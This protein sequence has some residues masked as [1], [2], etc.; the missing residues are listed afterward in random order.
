MNASMIWT[1]EITSDGHAIGTRIVAQGW[2]ILSKLAAVKAAIPTTWQAE[3][4]P[5][6]NSESSPSLSDSPVA[7]MIYPP[8]TYTE[9]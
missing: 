9:V 1:I 8:I 5:Q 6:I 3:A 4:Y 7:G 2:D